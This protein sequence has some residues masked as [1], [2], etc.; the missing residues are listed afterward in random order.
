MS[1]ISFHMPILFL[2]GHEHQNVGGEKTFLMLNKVFTFVFNLL[3]HPKYVNMQKKITRF[4][5]I[6]A[7]DQYKVILQSYLVE[8]YYDFHSIC[9]IGLG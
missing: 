8:K 1:P 3:L 7:L 9:K 4:T 2:F 5:G 6:M